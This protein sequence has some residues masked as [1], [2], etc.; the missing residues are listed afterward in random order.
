MVQTHNDPSAAV[1]QTHNAAG[2][3]MVQ[4]HNNGDA[5]VVRSHNNVEGRGASPRHAASAS[6]AAG[7]DPAADPPS[8][9]LADSGDASFHTPPENGRPLRFAVYGDVRSGHD[10]HAA[11]NQA[12]AD[13]QPD[14]AILTGDLVD[15]GSDEGDWERFFE[16]AGPLLRQLAIF[17]ATGNHE[18]A[19]RGQGL[20]TFMQLFR[21]PFAPADDPPWY[22]FDVAGSHFVA[23]DSNEYKQPRQL[24][25][26][27]HDLREAR[28]RH[29]RA[30][31]VYA[32]EGP[33]SAG[34]HGDNAVCAHD[35]VPIM[36]RYHVSMFFGGHDHD[37][38]RGRIGAL[39]YVV[40]GGGGAEL[41]PARC[42]VPGKKP[43]PPRTAIFVNDHNYVM[44]EVLPGLFRVCP[45]R[46]D[47]TPIE[48]CI[49]YPLR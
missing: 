14:L 6:A 3:N 25:W 19:K 21:W 10:I 37:Y 42:G 41:R 46:V 9:T 33:A 28:R 26:L 12:L 48:S 30:I 34:L 23:L 11:L 40:S 36:E 16:I 2:R 31:F 4:T 38:E 27:E 45:K 20:T 32:H 29:V 17:P 35:Y 13:E 22:S 44:V 18:Y 49:Q 1:V 39:D 43:C 24:S 15:R 7:D 5:R 47:G 8:G